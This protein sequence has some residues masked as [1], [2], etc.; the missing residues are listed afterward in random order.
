MGVQQYALLS[1]FF[2]FELDHAVRED[3]ENK[4]RD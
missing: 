3:P 4:K 1:L 2:T